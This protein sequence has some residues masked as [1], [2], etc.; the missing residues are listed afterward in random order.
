MCKQHARL[1]PAEVTAPDSPATYRRICEI[2]GAPSG[3]PLLW[4]PVSAC[5]GHEHL[6]PKRAPESVASLTAPACCTYVHVTDYRAEDA[7]PQMRG[8]QPHSFQDRYFGLSDSNSAL[9]LVSENRTESALYPFTD[10][11]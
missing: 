11:F 10:D 3:Q 7:K 5:S 8:F 2:C 6:L 9:R 4:R 1:F